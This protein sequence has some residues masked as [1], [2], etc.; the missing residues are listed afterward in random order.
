MH[1][2]SPP[3]RWRN[4]TTTFLSCIMSS[5]YT[6]W[7]VWHV[8]SDQE[9]VW[10]EFQN[11]NNHACFAAHF[12]SFSPC[13]SPMH[14]CTLNKVQLFTDTRVTYQKKPHTK[15]PWYNH[16]ERAPSHCFAGQGGEMTPA[17]AMGELWGSRGRGFWPRVRTGQLLPRMCFFWTP[18]PCSSALWELRCRT[19]RKKL[20]VDFFVSKQKNWKILE[21]IKMMRVPIMVSALDA[22]PPPTIWNCEIKGEYGIRRHLEAS[23]PVT[24]ASL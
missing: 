18:A 15:E 14:P 22:P 24:H 17:P 21:L 16:K 10:N 3:Q 1:I 11:W 19:N 8:K 6:S 9:N 23:V 13:V 20:K 5:I 12:I 7:Y 2:Y 4:I